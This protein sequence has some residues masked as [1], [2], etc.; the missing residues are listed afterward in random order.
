M[1]CIGQ[2]LTKRIGLFFIRTEDRFF[3]LSFSFSELDF[4]EEVADIGI[5]RT[6]GMLPDDLYR[7]IR[8]LIDERI[9]LLS[10]M[11]IF[12]QWLVTFS[13]PWGKGAIID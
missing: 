13:G 4:P 9:V 8:M 1:M 11:N 10:D 6:V 5:M 2:F 12:G 7:R 3:D